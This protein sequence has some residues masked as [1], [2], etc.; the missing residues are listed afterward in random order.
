MEYLGLYGIFVKSLL[1]STPI[2]VALLF[3]I[4]VAVT[5]VRR[6]ASKVAW[7]LLF[8]CGLLLVARIA[9]PAGN[10]VYWQWAEYGKYSHGLPFIFKSINHN[11]GVVGLLC[12]A[13]SFLGM[14]GLKRQEVNNVS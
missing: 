5:I 7:F 2:I 12:L 13:Y 9:V 1:Y 3:G 14:F 11:T 6:S 4:F 8:G 10:F